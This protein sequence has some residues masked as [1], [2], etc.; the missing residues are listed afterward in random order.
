VNDTRCRIVIRELYS[1]ISCLTSL[2]IL[3]IF[4]RN[5]C[6]LQKV[7]ESLQLSNYMS[8]NFMEIIRDMFPGA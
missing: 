1:R 7:S 4:R 6:T 8:G 2:Y 5:T 3:R